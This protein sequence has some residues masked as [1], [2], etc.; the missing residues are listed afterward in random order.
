MEIRPQIQISQLSDGTVIACVRGESTLAPLDN[1]PIIADPMQFI[2]VLSD[3]QLHLLASLAH[4][5]RLNGPIGFN[6]TNLS[7]LEELQDSFDIFVEKT[8]TGYVIT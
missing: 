8:T 1:E 4:S 6:T 7:L 5:R 3:D 2:G